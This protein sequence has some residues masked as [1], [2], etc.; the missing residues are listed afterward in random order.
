MLWYQELY[1]WH[2][3]A[4]GTHQTHLHIHTHTHT[5][6]IDIWTFAPPWLCDSIYCESL[7]S[8]V[9][10]KEAAGPIQLDTC[11]SLQCHVERLWTSLPTIPVLHLDP[12]RSIWLA[13]SLHQMPMWIAVA[14]R[15][16]TLHWQL[17]CQLTNLSDKAGQIHKCKWWLCGSLM[18]TI[19]CVL[20]VHWSQ[21]TFLGIIVF[22]ILFLK[23][24][25]TC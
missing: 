4:D 10:L 15:G 2:I 14:P 9:L 6:A 13:S 20:C 24:S 1:T 11:G 5:H 3:L 21:N 22:F 8:Q 18:C 19:S 23:F 17:L 16:Y 25:H 12:L 7:A